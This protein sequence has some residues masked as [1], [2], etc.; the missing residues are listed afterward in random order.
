MK[1]TVLDGLEYWGAYQPD[2]RIDFNGFYWRGPTPVLVDP[3][4]LG[5][6]QLARLEELGGAEAIVLTNFDH[7][8]ATRELKARLGAR[9]HAP[10]GERA[11]FGDAADLVDVWYADGDALPEGLDVHWI[12]GGKS[13]VEAALILEPLDAL[14]FGDVVR[15]HVSGALRLLP[16]EKLSDRAAVVESL[17]PLARRKVRA[18]LLG[19][20]DNVFQGAQSVW[21]AFLTE[22]AS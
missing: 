19:D 5:E 21:G 13:E 1:S 17:Q 7:L 12:R 2:R 15:S 18:L 22:L 4:P 16:D 11:R 3:M 10:E 6:E 14:L 20:G 8:R 9:V